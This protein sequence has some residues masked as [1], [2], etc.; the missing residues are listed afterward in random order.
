MLSSDL[1]ED[2]KRDL[3]DLG[4]SEYA[5][6][7]C[8]NLSKLP[9]GSLDKYDQGVMFATYSTLISKKKDT[10]QTRLG[11]LLEWCGEN[12]DGLI[13]LDECHK[14]KTIVLDPNGNPKKAGKYLKCTLTATRVVELQNSLP[15][16]RVVY[17]SAT[18]VSEEKN[19]G[20]MSR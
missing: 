7:N 2:A 15:R 8:L 6:T 1:Y 3:S 10:N 14:A 17:C 5:K 16:A 19:L 9:Y 18:S 20:F 12:F 4:L 11:Q 13:M